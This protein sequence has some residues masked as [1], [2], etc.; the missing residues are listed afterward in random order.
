MKILPNNLRDILKEPIGL[1]LDEKKL[2]KLLKNER[3]IISIGDIVTYTLLKNNIKPFLGIV[4]YKTRRGACTEEIKNVIK[5]FG[6]KI[7]VQNPPGCISDD[8]WEVM[9]SVLKD[10]RYGNILIEIEGEED[11]ASLAAIYLAPEN[12]SIVYG[13]PDKGILLIKPTKKIKR[14]VEEVLKRMV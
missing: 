5:S 9:E 8:L 6:K 13:L 10:L 4:D 14:K 1:L 3:Y 2:V 12:V 7:I 11:L